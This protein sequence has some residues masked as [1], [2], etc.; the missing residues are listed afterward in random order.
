MLGSSR[1]FEVWQPPHV[2]FT[3]HWD[4]W[5]GKNASCYIEN[6]LLLSQT[7]TFGGLP[8]PRAY[9]LHV[10]FQLAILVPNGVHLLPGHVW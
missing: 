6:H 10:K 8:Q 3:L 9:A 4:G 1:A 7:T 5:D 2:G